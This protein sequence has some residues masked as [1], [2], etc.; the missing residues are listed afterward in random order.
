MSSSRVCWWRPFSVT[1]TRSN[2]IQQ[3]CVST[4]NTAHQHRQCKIQQSQ[5]RLA[6]TRANPAFMHLPITRFNAEPLAI[7]L[8]HPTRSTNIHAIVRKRERPATMFAAFASQVLTI[9]VDVFFLFLTVEIS[10]L[11]KPLFFHDAYLRVP[12]AGVFFVAFLPR[13]TTGIM[14]G[15][16]KCFK[17]EI[18]LTL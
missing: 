9:H 11:S 15:T 4:G 3:L 18:T 13:I 5:D 12:P 16:C 2:Q 10:Y 1:H 8:E 7:R 14:N 6:G 17:Y